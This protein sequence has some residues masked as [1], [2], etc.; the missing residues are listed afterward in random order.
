MEDAATVR[1]ESRNLA[2]VCSA[3][4]WDGQA[5]LH[6][7]VLNLPLQHGHAV[8]THLLTMVPLNMALST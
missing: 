7:E 6:K 4:K 8:F 2:V 5:Q 3:P 1:E